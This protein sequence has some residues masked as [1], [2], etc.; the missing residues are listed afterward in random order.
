[1]ILVERSIKLRAGRFV[2]FDHSSGWSAIVRDTVA[3][4]LDRFHPFP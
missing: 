4:R 2:V 3:H 1:M